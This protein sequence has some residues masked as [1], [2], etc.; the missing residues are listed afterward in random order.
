M[1]L[2]R[3]I[4]AVTLALI[5]VAGYNIDHAEAIP[6][7]VFTASTDAPHAGELV[8]FDASAST[9]D[10]GPCSFKGQVTWRSPGCCG[11][12]HTIAQLRFVSGIASYTFTALDATHPYVT[13][14]VSAIN[15][16]STHNFRSS[17]Q[18]FT[19]TP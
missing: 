13:V 6:V 4:L 19:V 9:C 16:N 17:S 15:G 1:T 14:T 18:T 8:T 7:A 5:G 10:L 12:T 3:L 2:R 11:A